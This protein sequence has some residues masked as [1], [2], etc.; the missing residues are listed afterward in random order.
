MPRRWRRALAVAALVALAVQSLCCGAAQNGTKGGKKKK[1]PA[2]FPRTILQIGPP[3]AATSLQFATL[4]ASAAARFMNEPEVEVL[5]GFNEWTQVRACV[6]AGVWSPR[7]PR[8]HDT[9]V[10]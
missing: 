7:G 2:P 5:C 6:C 4:C 8:I 1:A 10:A 9:S 3:R